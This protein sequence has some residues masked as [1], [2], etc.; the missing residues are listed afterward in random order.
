MENNGQ[1]A[2]PSSSSLLIMALQSLNMDD[3][4]EQVNQQRREGEGGGGGGDK[5][6]TLAKQ[7]YLPD[8]TIE[9]TCAFQLSDELDLD[10]I[11]V[12]WL[13]LET[14]SN[15][16]R[17]V[18]RSTNGYL[19][20]RLNQTAAAAAASFSQTDLAQTLQQ[21]SATSKDYA[22]ID[23][24]TRVNGTIERWPP[25]REK[26]QDEQARKRRRRRRRKNGTKQEVANH[27]LGS[28]SKAS[29]LERKLDSRNR[30]NDNDNGDDHDDR[31]ESEPEEADEAGQS[32]K[33][34]RVLHL[35]AAGAANSAGN[36]LPSGAKNNE[37]P[38]DRFFLCR[39]TNKAGQ[40]DLVQPVQVSSDSQLAQRDSRRR[41]AM[42]RLLESGGGGIKSS[43]TAHWIPFSQLSTPIMSFNQI[44]TTARSLSWPLDQV[45]SS[46]ERELLTA[47]NGSTYT[48]AR[49]LFIPIHLPEEMLQDD[50]RQIQVQPQSGSSSSE[51]D[52]VSSSARSLN[53]ASNLNQFQDHQRPA[54]RETNATLNNTI[55]AKSKTKPLAPAKQVDGDSEGNI[56]RALDDGDRVDDLSSK[57][58]RRSLRALAFSLITRYTSNIG[59]LIDP[60]ESDQSFL[61]EFNLV[62]NDKNT[63]VHLKPLK[64]NA[65]IANDDSFGAL[66]QRLYVRYLDKKLQ[67]LLVGTFIGMLVSCIVIL[68]IKVRLR[69]LRTDKRRVGDLHDGDKSTENSSS[70][71]EED[72]HGDVGADEEE[73][74]EEEEEDTVINQDPIFICKTMANFADGKDSL[75]PDRFLTSGESSSSTTVG[76]Q[77]KL[78]VSPCPYS[79]AARP[80][81]GTLPATTCMN[82]R[83]NPPIMNQQDGMFIE[84][85]ATSVDSSMI[86]GD[87]FYELSLDGHQTVFSLLP[88]HADLD[89]IHA[90]RLNQ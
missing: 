14:V 46:I 73:A 47:D 59:A 42:R 70:L 21:K 10:L 54:T 28:V 1:Q 79:M 58:P 33:L 76:S 23:Y 30:D 84:F 7:H 71:Q 68:V 44:T 9:L 13:H 37:Q 31:A 12:E 20:N 34:I 29:L 86:G 43:P 56:Q 17:S 5:L 90:S 74:D 67:P 72:T 35:I 39:I 22:I 41:Q 78:I 16:W 26:V 62:Q 27:H 19:A 40:V 50:G 81:V 75:A 38:L 24:V 63:V 88:H 69:C 60:V 87:E 61:D 49:P 45:S 51:L 57:N 85:R 53:N 66:L 4:R 36:P 6:L 2:P 55:G 89:S 77:K 3:K 11:Q 32:M 18:W 52:G 64:S 83:F 65:R 15:R 25:A 8:E 82:E 48:T 80:F